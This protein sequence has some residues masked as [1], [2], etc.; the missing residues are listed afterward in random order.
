MTTIDTPEPLVPPEV[1]LRDFRDFPLDFKRLFG[2]DTWIECDAEEKVAALRLWCLSMHQE[3][4]GSLPN[5]DRILAEL[6][7]YGVAVKEFMKIK[8]SAM[9]G[10]ILCADG[11]L[12]HPVVAEKM[13][14]CWA[15]KR[16]KESENA[17]D[18]ERKKRKKEALSGR[19]TAPVPP[20]HPGVP[21][22]RPAVPPDTPPEIRPEIVLSRSRSRRDSPEPKG[23]GADAPP[24]RGDP[25]AIEAEV[26]RVGKRVLGKGAGG[27]ITKLRRID[28]MTDARAL[29]LL[30][31]SETKENPR[32]WI[33]AIIR[34]GDPEGELQ[35][36]Q[37]A[38]YRGVMI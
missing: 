37:A 10:W 32:E 19:N 5:N 9:R 35:R 31:Q 17:A 33:G 21:P 12:Y 26:F 11:R 24:G 34:N 36:Q 13:I 8:S 16:R 23:S 1:D 3:P 30:S 18:R 22:E 4:A 25:D 6:A 7:G 20:E 28:G 38:I 14:N 2:S 27:L 15:K 29:E